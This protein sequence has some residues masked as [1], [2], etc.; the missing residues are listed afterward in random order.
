M[1][2]LEK[3]KIIKTLKKKDLKVGLFSEKNHQN[4]ITNFVTMVR[5]IKVNV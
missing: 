3:K 4:E 5:K 1:K 2:K